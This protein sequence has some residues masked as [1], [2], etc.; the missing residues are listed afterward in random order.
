MDTTKLT[1]PPLNTLGLRG[2]RVSAF[3][4]DSEHA[5]VIY[6]WYEHISDA[7]DV[8]VIASVLGPDST[9]IL[10]PHQW[11]AYAVNITEFRRHYYQS[12][13]HILQVQLF[14]AGTY[15]CVTTF[16]AAQFEVVVLG[17]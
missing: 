3:C 6:S 16:W 9:G 1:N 10:H 7:N 4:L 15:S 11:D 8:T 13:L 12:W 17:E 5:D 2:Q 14:D